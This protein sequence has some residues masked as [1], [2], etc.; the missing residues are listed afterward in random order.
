MSDGTIDNNEEL[1]LRDEV[2][3]ESD[4]W[5]DL[6]TDWQAWQLEKGLDFIADKERW[7]LFNREACVD[8]DWET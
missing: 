6:L 8:R 1:D 7:D 3:E 5:S 2:P 4:W